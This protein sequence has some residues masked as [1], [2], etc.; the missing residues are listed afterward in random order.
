MSTPRSLADRKAHLVAQADLQRL[1]LAFAWREVRSVLS[2]PVPPERAAW[3]RPKVAA[4]L[5]VALPLVGA[6]R[7][8]RVVRVL[9][10]VLMV[11][12]AA[13]S[14]RAGA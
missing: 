9:S 14:W 7:L 3:A 2:P 10:I 12:R 4:F 6:R 5:G 11:Y 1:R 8:G 13:R